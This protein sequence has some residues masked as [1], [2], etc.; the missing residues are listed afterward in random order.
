MNVTVSNI[1]FFYLAAMCILLNLSTTGESIWNATVLLVWKSTRKHGQSTMGSQPIR[2][3]N[4]PKHISSKLML[5]GIMSCLAL[6]PMQVLAFTPDQV[7]DKV[8]DSIVAVKTLDAKGTIM[9]QGSGVLISSDTVATSCHVLGRGASYLAGRSNRLV[10]A[11]LYAEDGDKDICLLTAKDVDGN[12][13]ELGK[14][15]GL[16]TWNQVYAV[17]VSPGSDPSLREG[18]V[19][20][21]WGIPTPLIRITAVISPEMSGGGLFDGEGKLVGLTTLYKEGEQ[22]LTLAI[23]AEWIGD[24]KPGR[25]PA[26]GR[27]GEVE[28]LKHSVIL[29][30]SGDW[31]GLHAWGLEWSKVIPTSTNAH[32]FLGKAARI[33]KRHNE[34]V[35]AFR[36]ALDMD[37]QIAV[38]WYNLGITYSG[39]KRHSDAIECY[40]KALSAE[41]DMTDAWLNLGVTYTLTGNPTAA[42]DVAK[43]LRRFDPFNADILLNVIRSNRL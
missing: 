12:P 9:N 8:K 28:W 24:V 37:P 1:A 33:L 43:E 39:L 30:T 19:A 7:F 10:S 34:A 3:V 20:K 15:K 14:A 29:E 41:P 25:K 27:K 31:E 42:M 23:P 36:Q 38:V 17:G 35:D 26:E 21:L 40:R 13:A 32:Y 2:I 22:T 5:F 18:T 11:V 16:K 6:S 4:M